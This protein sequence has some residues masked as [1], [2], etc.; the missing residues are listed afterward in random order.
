MQMTK[1]TDYGLRLL[2]ALS[3]TEKSTVGAGEIATQ[4]GI[5]QHHVAKIATSLVAGGFIVSERGRNG[6]LRLA[7][8]ADEISLGA[9]VRHLSQ[10]EKLV[11]CMGAGP[12]GCCIVP[13]C[14]LR[15]PLAEAEEAFYQVLD[16]HS[17]ADCA[18]QRDALR[19][20]LA[21]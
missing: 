8:G 9:V 17:I 6:G 5:S 15:G 3:V 7:R 2:I 4:Y 20:L 14:G 21:S 13:A 10:G 16:K 19:A 1:F 11:E 18:S 12:V